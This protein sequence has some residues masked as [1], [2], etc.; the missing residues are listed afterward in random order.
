MSVPTVSVADLVRGAQG[1]LVGGSLERVVSGVSI[2]SRT[3][4]PGEIFF[5]IRGHHADGHAYLA[6]ALGRGAGAAVV[7]RY[8]SALALPAD[9]PVV[10]VEDTTRALQRLGAFHRRRHTL[11]V[12]GVTGSIGKTTTKELAAAVLAERFHVL[13]A[14]GSFN[15]QWGVPLTLLGLE[16]THGAAVLELGMNAFGEI[17]ALAQLARPTVGVVTAIAP[18]H[19]EGVGSLEGVQKAKGELVEAI[20]AEGVVILN[21]DDPLV[22]ALAAAARGRVVTYGR[23]PRADVRLSEVAPV[24]GGLHFTVAYGGETVPMRLPLPGRHNAGNAAAAVA[25][26]LALGVPL[27]AAAAGLGR[28]RPVKGRLHWRRAGGVRLLDDTYN[29]SPV[30][31]RAALDALREAGPD[32]R[33]WVVFGDMLELGPASDAAHLEAGRWI[34]TLPVAGLATAGAASR[35]TAAEA[36]GAGCP[37]VAACATP[38]EAAA[39]VAARVRP[40][41]RVLV[42]GSRGMRMEGA[43]AALLER[44]GGEGPAC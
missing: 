28:V 41:D 17:A 13:K 37:D 18:A 34:A 14:S 19:L 38:Q 42:K 10:L 3:C 26:G 40:G 1:A 35:A 36:A 24:E 2:D 43:I 8:P 15:N 31:L 25:I 32:G 16:A 5:A 29:A 21:A 4:R 44:L 30:S 6:D 27:A 23:A 39:H 11:P 33:V 7:S 20:P 12:V 22:L 9:F